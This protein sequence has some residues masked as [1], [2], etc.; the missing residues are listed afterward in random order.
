MV[1]TQPDTNYF[2]RQSMRPGVFVAGAFL[3]LVPE[4][5]G[6]KEV[7]EC[8]LAQELKVKPEKPSNGIVD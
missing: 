1:D 5:E 2:L 7:L 8:K 3:K 4:E 6:K